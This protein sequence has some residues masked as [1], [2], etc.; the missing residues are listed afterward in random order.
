MDVPTPS[1]A[2]DE[3]IPSES[4][5]DAAISKLRN[6]ITPQSAPPQ[7]DADRIRS[8]IA[9]F[10]SSSVE[11]LEGMTAELQEL[12][13]LLRVEARRVHGKIES[14]LAGIDILM[15]TIAPW[16]STPSSQSPSPARTVRR[17]S[18]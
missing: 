16:K 11:G 9:R 13:T 1:V 18:E 8:S 12:Q 17:T 5:L 14:A 15:E 10:T 2:A 6:Q 7:S 4:Q 3:S